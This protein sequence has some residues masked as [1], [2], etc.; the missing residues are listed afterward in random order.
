MML[1]DKDK[2]IKKAIKIMGKE[3]INPIGE[4]FESSTMCLLN[5]KLNKEIIKLKNVRLCHGIGIS[6]MYGTKDTKIA[7]SW[8][9]YTHEFEDVGNKRM[10]IDTT[11][12]I[13]ILSS[14]YRKQLKL[15]YVIEYTPKEA[16][17]NWK[18]EVPPWDQKI[19]NIINKK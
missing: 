6:N 5:P 3:P 1:K 10:A 13:Q 9:E 7:H 18:K 8:I 4:C 16:L 11:W 2:Y 12:G 19:K 17:E 14:V 15:K